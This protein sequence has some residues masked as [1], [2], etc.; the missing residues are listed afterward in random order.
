MRTLYRDFPL[1]AERYDC[2]HFNGSRGHVLGLGLRRRITIHEFTSSV[3]AQSPIRNALMG[4]ARGWG[5]L[6]ASRMWTMDPGY[7]LAI[8]DMLHPTP[9]HGCMHAPLTVTKHPRHVDSS[10]DI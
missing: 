1:M 5:A 2:E 10:Y 6:G 9:N 7:L 3:V 8:A 4:M